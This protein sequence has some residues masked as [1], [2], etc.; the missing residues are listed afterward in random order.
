MGDKDQ[1][2]QNYE[3]DVIQ[4]EKKK[5]QSKNVTPTMAHAVSTP[6]MGMRYQ[7]I[8][9]YGTNWGKYKPRRINDSR[10]IPVNWILQPDMLHRVLEK[11]NY[12]SKTYWATY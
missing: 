7:K 8:G 3:V 12:H 1:K 5:E 9:D 2:E 4:E 6:N 10:K 11:D